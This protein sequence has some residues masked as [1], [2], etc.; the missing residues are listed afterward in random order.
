MRIAPVTAVVVAFDS[1]HALPDCLGALARE[2]V[3]AVVVDNASAD[4]SAEVAGRLGA[5]V[6]RNPLN[7]GYGRAN[8]RGVAAA[9]TPFVLIINPDVILEE[10]AAAALLKAAERYPD[11]GLLAPVLIE[12]DG[13]HFFQPRSLLAPYLHNPAGIER[14]PEGDCCTPFLSGAV[15]L[16]RRELFLGLGGFDPRI[17][18]FYEDDDLCRRVADAGHSLIH[19]AGAVA[20]HGR[21]RSSAP[22]PGR[23]FR[24]RWH[25]AWSRAYVSRKYG[26]PNP[27]PAMAFKNALKWL[28]AALLFHRGRM[29][30]YGGSA[31][32]AIAALRGA[33]ALAYQ[34]LPS[35]EE[36]RRP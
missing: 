35:R 10:G 23:I 13:R 7:E 14:L 6:I 20:R 28:G 12:P 9:L 17:F 36:A 26:L 5:E 8:N 31:A 3:P 29:A 25:Q 30:R 11:A 33:D 2:G 27:A 4:G 18:L 1:A 21:G 22:A 34:G 32:G 15:F 19:V 24:G 16:M